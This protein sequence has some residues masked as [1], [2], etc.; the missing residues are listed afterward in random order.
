MRQG[1]ES[2][3]CSTWT[4]RAGLNFN[5]C[6]FILLRLF[7]YDYDYL[8]YLLCAYVYLLEHCTCSGMRQNILLLLLL[9]C[10][11]YVDVFAFARVAGLVRKTESLYKVTHIDNF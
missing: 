5:L 1:K 7:C 6:L 2:W 4:S 11:H 9:L 8:F 10:P 3:C